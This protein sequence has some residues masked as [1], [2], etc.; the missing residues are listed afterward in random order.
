MNRGTAIASRYE[1]QDPDFGYLGIDDVP[2]LHYNYDEI[3]PLH[4]DAVMQ[5]AVAIKRHLRKAQENVIQVG[6]WLTKVK[7]RLPHGQWEDWCERELGSPATARNYISVW[8]KLGKGKKGSELVM[9]ESLGRSTLYLLARDTTP[10][11]ARERVYEEGKGG[12]VSHK[13]AKQIVEQEKRAASLSQRETQKFSDLDARPALSAHTAT[14]RYSDAAQ[15]DVDR[16]T[17]AYAADP[18]A[19]DESS[20]WEQIEAGEPELSV[21]E[22]RFIYRRALDIVPVLERHIGRTLSALRQS[23]QT[24]MEELGDVDA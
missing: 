2:V 7:Q 17:E 1:A 24:V 3:D 12:P 15:G 11:S 8:E 13:R 5:A 6:K 14:S 9:F 10:D 18:S 22:L 20:G 4:R 19:Y 16:K 23:L 21:D